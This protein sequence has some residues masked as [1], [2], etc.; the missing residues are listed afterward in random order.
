MIWQFFYHFYF[1]IIQ[2]CL[3]LFINFMIYFTINHCYKI[4]FNLISIIRSFANT[5][6]NQNIYNFVKG[7][8]FTFL[9]GLTNTLNF[10]WENVS[11]N[12]DYWFMFEISNRTM[13]YLSQ[14]EVLFLH[15]HFSR[16]SPSYINQEESKKVF[17]REKRDFL[18]WYMFKPIQSINCHLHT[19]GFFSCFQVDAVLCRKY[20][21]ALVYG[22]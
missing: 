22:C 5:E 9:L 16:T 11:S 7:Y 2:R 6:I 10:H 18:L 8:Y 17:S 12:I 20:L 19:H 1:Q 15:I 21:Q 13:A 3:H 14:R 4:N